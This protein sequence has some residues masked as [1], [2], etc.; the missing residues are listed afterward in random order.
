MP[1]NYLKSISKKYDVDIKE[2]EKYWD[3]AKSSV[4]TDKEDDE[5]YGTVTKIFKA[6]IAKHMGINEKYT[7]F[8]FNNILREKLEISV[9]GKK[10]LE[11]FISDFLRL[12]KDIFPISDRLNKILYSKIPT[13]KA[14]HVTNILNVKNIN[15]LQNTKRSISVFNKVNKVGI[16]SAGVEAGGGIVFEVNGN[17]LIKSPA[18]LYT[19]V[20]DR[21]RRWVSLERIK[22]QLYSSKHVKTFIGYIK[23]IQ[24]DFDLIRDDLE[25]E[26]MEAF[27][28][29]RHEEKGHKKLMGTLVRKM[30]KQLD[31][32]FNKFKK[33]YLE[34]FTEM[35]LVDFKDKMDYDESVVNHIK[36]KNIFIIT[37]NLEDWQIKEY[38]TAVRKEFNFE[39][40]LANVSEFLQIIKK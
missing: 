37:N 29:R 27:R 38:E 22:S 35:A 21:G 15:D 28:A 24:T 30:F 26:M 25:D 23:R 8:R 32:H 4:D 36:V 2:L 3:E 6:K 9:W 11:D 34:I 10:T 19:E 13:T 33:E 12:E 5:Y 20:D 1:A 40:T 7:R 16:L 17:V 39:P 18:D 14:Y 31:T